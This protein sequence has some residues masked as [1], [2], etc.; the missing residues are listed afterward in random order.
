MEQLAW[1]ALSDPTRRTILDLLRGGLRDR[2]LEQLAN[3]PEVEE[4]KGNLFNTF[5]KMLG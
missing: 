5:F 4:K 3:P 2:T 1:K